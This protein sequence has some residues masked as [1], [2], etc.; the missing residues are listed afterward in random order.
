VIYDQLPAMRLHTHGENLAKIGPV[1]PELA[2][3]KV[4][5]KQTGSHLEMVGDMSRVT[6]NFDFIKNPFCAFLARVKTY[7]YTKN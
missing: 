4:Y 6:L 1:Y 3:L 5:F 2:L 7:T